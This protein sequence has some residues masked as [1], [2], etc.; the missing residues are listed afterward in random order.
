MLKHVTFGTAII[1]IIT[2][3]NSLTSLNFIDLFE[4]F[5]YISYI[6]IS[7]IG[8]TIFSLFGCGWIV[9]LGIFDKI[10]QQI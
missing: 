6:F 8:L 7:N 5:C 1:A 10:E 9:R 3:L 2:I 4:Q